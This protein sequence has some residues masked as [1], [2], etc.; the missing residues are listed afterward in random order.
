MSR[1]RRQVCTR[2]RAMLRR[3]WVELLARVGVDDGDR[4]RR[5]ALGCGDQL[6]ERRGA[7]GDRDVV[8]VERERVGCGVDAVAV[9]RAGAGV[10]A[11]DGVHAATSVMYG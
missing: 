9:G 1:T 7:R 8:A 6:V 2:A 11:G 3:L 5:A 4:D 10:D